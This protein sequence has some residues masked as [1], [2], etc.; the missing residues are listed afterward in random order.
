[1]SDQLQE[2]PS[3][4]IVSGLPRS[5]TTWLGKLF[6]SHPST[7]YRHEPDS[8]ERPR[9]LPLAVEADFRKY[10]RPLRQYVDCLSQIRVPKVSASA[11]VFPKAFMTPVQQFVVRYSNRTVKILSSIGIEVRVPR[12][13]IPDESKRFVLVWK[14][15]NSSGRL[16]LYSMALQN[17]RIIHLLRHPCGIIFSRTQGEKLNKFGGYRAAEDFDMFRLLLDT[18]IGRQSD[19]S[20]NDIKAMAPI[21]RLAWECLISMEMALED[22]KG[23]PES[24]IVIYED[25]CEKPHEVMQK[26]FDFCDLDFDPQCQ[27]FLSEST[28]K[29]NNNRY[30]S[31]YK[32]PLYSAYKW[33]KNLSI[34][35][36]ELV[37]RHLEK[38]PLAR[39]WPD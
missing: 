32:D 13:C 8:V 27:R 30:Y 25:L 33:K 39:F 36:Q 26:I 6:D 28:S 10:E 15:I 2:K 16:G 21:E 5:G 20:L 37:G 38:S 14:T 23:R 3:L 4:I 1:M 19:L 18:S 17:K 11:I 22:L 9:W 34:A 31:L 7:L 35:D 29:T 12:F 24:M